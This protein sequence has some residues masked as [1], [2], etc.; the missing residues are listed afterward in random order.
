VGVREEAA[1][2]AWTDG[3]VELVEDQAALPPWASRLF[4]GAS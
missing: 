1:G 2:L 4:A 3:A